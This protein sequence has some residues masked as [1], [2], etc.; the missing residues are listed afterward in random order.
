MVVSLGLSQFLY[1]FQTDSTT[2]DQHG[3]LDGWYLLG[4]QLPCPSKVVLSV[5]RIDVRLKVWCSFKGFIF[6]S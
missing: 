4:W 1:N 5:W 6:V 2:L 3:N